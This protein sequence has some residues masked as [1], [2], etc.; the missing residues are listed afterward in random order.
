MKLFIGFFM[1]FYLFSCN[2]PTVEP[3]PEPMTEVPE[4]SE[5]N[6]TFLALGDSYTIGQGVDAHERFPNQL[7]EM[8]GAVNLSFKEVKFIARTGWTTAD[9]KAGIAAE[10]NLSNNYDVVT[11]LI[12]VNN[13]YRGYPIDQYEREF[14]EL[15]QQAIHFADS[16]R[17]RVFVVSIPDYAYTPFGGGRE[18]ISEEIDRY[19]E[20]NR[21]FAEEAGVT[22]FDITPISRQGFEEP[23]LVAPDNLHPS[24]E[25][26]GRWAK[27]MSGKVRD[28]LSN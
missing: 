26:Y 1:S 17:S 25:Q 28:V 9:L 24:G 19:N 18:G 5:G 7:T 13:Q 2:S 6:L 22:Y 12:G 20:L 21:K 3:V 4:Q 23:N 11:L 16:V 10:E 27:L 14:P 8:L 15:L